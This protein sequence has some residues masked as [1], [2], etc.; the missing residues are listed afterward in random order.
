MCR[1]KS[2]ASSL[3]SVLEHNKRVR[4]NGPGAWIVG[5]VSRR[6]TQTG[7]HNKDMMRFRFDFHRARPDLFFDVI[8]EGH[9]VRGWPTT[10]ST[11]SSQSFSKL[12]F[13]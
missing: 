3:F 1:R 10:K 12:T 11:P 7:G 5:S 13:A 4:Q 9:L 8:D 6:R 2:R